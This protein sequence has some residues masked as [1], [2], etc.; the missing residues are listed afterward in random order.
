MVR[1]EVVM[2]LCDDDILYPDAFH[3]FASFFQTQPEALAAYA[4]QDVGVI[5]PNGHRAV[6]SERRAV[7]MAGRC[8]NGRTLDCQ[9]DYLQFCH[10]KSL[11]DKFDGNEWWNEGKGTESHADGVFMERCGTYTPIYPIDIKV[12]QNRRTPTSTYG[13]VK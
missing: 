13:P 12:S 8:C 11:L 6:V 4:S 10:R 7:G 2:Y 3:T 5:Y 9:V 1:G